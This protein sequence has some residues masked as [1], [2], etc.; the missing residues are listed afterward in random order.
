MTSV[1]WGNRLGAVLLCAWVAMALGCST[2]R[3]R[4]STFDS[5]YR[6]GAS[7]TVKRQ[8]WIKQQLER[9]ATSDE[10]P[11]VYVVDAETE[12]ADGRRLVPGQEVV[13]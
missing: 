6:Q 5:G 13:Q 4:Q 8:Y 12:T 1:T 3:G 7:D 10:R 9:R 11:R 2:R